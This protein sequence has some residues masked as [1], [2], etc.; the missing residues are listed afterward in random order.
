MQSA[1]SAEVGGV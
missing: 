1:Y